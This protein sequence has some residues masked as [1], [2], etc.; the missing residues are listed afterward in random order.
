MTSEAG[1]PDI[2]DRQASSR[3]YPVFVTPTLR[4]AS[5][6]GLGELRAPSLAEG[7]KA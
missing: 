5:L 1:L 7:A 2:C 3:R 4:L 6:G